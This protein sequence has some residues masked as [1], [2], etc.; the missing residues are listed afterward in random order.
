MVFY[1]NIFKSKTIILSQ[2]YYPLMQIAII[3][4][5]SIGTTLA[6][7]IENMAEIEKVFIFDRTGICQR[8]TGLKKTVP[9]EKLEDVIDKVDLVI[10][11]A[12]PQAV[13]QY[14][15]F[16]LNNKKNLM[17]MSIGALLDTE[18]KNKL[19]NLARKNKC[20]IYLP[21]GAICGIDGVKTCSIEK[22]DEVI[23]ITKKPPKAFEGNE[24]LKQKGIILEKIKEETVVFEGNSIDAIKYFPQNINV[25]AT[26]TLASGKIA[27][28]KIILCPEL[29]RNEHKII[30]KGNF[31]EIVCEAKNNPFKA[32]PK[33]SY[34]AGLSAIATLKRIISPLEVGT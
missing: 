10:E 15:E 17:I 32:N 24:Y 11:S 34:L 16:V 4:C 20:K 33:T 7:A 22:I 9:I 2:T 3:G 6:R 31:G 27:K 28:V 13:K 8:I 25:S 26:L 21:S 14:A 30:L 5:G 18:F 23:L 19:V 12:S 29:K 1:K